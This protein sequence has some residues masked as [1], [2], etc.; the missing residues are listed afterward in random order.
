MGEALGL[1][2]LEVA[3][4]LWVDLDDALEQVVDDGLAAARERG[5]DA[6]ERL[7]RLLLDLGRRRRAVA[8]VL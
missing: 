1:V 3:V 5:L 8:R 4:E 6:L 2:H 7:V